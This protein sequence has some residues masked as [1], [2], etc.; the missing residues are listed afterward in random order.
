M[1][2]KELFFVFVPGISAILFALGGTKISDTCPGW[3][4]WRRFIL[5]CIYCIACIMAHIVI[6]K[7][8]FVTLLACFVF[9]LGYGEGKS[10]IYRTFVGCYYALITLP[11]GLSVWNIYT[12][13]GF[14]VM[15][16]LSNQEET[17]H[18]F[19]WKICENA[20]GALCGIQLAFLLCK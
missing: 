10:W 19:V 5:P 14:I 16:W 7:A 3:K 2:N 13:L 11:I 18:I 6:W 1:L 17:G 20:F 9:S 8:I 15:F 12:A 4:G